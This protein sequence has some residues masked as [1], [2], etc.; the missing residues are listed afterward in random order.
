M[1]MSA[2]NEGNRQNNCLHNRPDLP[3]VPVIEQK[4]SRRRAV[5]TSYHS[6]LR[7]R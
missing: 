7:P 1:V 5:L 3:P 4:Y 2:R 6:L